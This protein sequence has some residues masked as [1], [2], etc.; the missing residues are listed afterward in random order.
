MKWN[1]VIDSS[2]DILGEKPSEDIGL[3]MVPIIVMVGEKEFKDDE[4]INI[5]E[6]IEAMAQEK[7][8][9]STA[10]PSPHAFLE[11]Y[12][13]ADYTICI[14]ITS[15]LSATYNSAL[16]AV[17]M[18]KEECPEKKVLVIDSKATSPKM[19]VIKRKAESLIREGK[20]F[21]EICE[22][23]PKYAEDAGFVF[24]LGAYDNLV[25]TG[26]MSKTAGVLATK[27]GIR[28]IATASEEGTIQVVKKPRGEKNAIKEMVEFAKQNKKIEDSRVCIAHCNNLEG[29]LNLK[30]KVIEELNPETIEI[31]ECRGLTT[32]YTM[33]NGLLLGF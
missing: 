31:F 3:S 15:G 27:V 11:E 25:K 32:F 28:A 30:E 26:R 22:I 29:A 9:L 19:V 5:K 13:K 1:I 2:S 23:L 10:C 6:L 17:D 14:T 8:A 24:A 33:Q 16:L 4:T 21:E 7:T 18:L 20:T 12:K